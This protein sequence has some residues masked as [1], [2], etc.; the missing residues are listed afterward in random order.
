MT[1]IG[2]ALHSFQSLFIYIIWAG[3]CIKFA[4]PGMTSVPTS[5]ISQMRKQVLPKAIQ[6]GLEPRPA[7]KYSKSGG[8][9][10]KLQSTV[11]MQGAA[12]NIFLN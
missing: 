10:W 5:S 7:L 2:I 6:P 1:Y 4:N 9:T 12:I 11:Q 8:D 3:Q